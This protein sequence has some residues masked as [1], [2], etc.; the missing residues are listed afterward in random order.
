MTSKLTKGK[1]RLP[2]RTAK[3]TWDE[4]NSIF[5]GAE[6]R[7]RLDV[8]IGQ[9]TEIQD[10]VDDGKAMHGFKLFGDSVLVEWNLE[11]DKGEAI[12]PTGEGMQQV[13]PAF[14]SSLI[15]IWMNHVSQ[16]P[17]PLGVPSPNGDTSL[18]Q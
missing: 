1:F 16:I 15:E 10:L 17:D 11:N 8:T 12:P 2:Q 3:L 13:S 6:V 18:E 5:H 4:E 7:T 9:L 14:A